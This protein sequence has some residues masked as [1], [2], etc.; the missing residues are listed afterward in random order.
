MLLTFL[1]YAVPNM[2]T[3]G[4]AA[5]VLYLPSVNSFIGYC[6]WNDFDLSYSSLSVSTFSPIVFAALIK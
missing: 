2:N 4:K 5:T 1:L 6:D 3:C